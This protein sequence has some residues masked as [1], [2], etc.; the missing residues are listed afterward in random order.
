MGIFFFF[1]DKLSWWFNLLLEATKKLLSC[2]KRGEVSYESI[3]V[4]K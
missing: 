1:V 3:Y 2:I 4:E